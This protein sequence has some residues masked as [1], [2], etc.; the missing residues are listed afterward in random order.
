MS[1]CHGSIELFPGVFTQGVCGSGEPHDSHDFTADERVC[2]GSPAE[3][4]EADCGRPGPH[5]EHPLNE[6]PEVSQ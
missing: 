1:H 5:G 3:F 6:A 2:L 4:I